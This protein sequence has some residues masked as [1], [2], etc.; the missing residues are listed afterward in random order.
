MARNSKMRPKRVKHFAL[1]V[2]I[3]TLK[4][5]VLFDTRISKQKLRRSVFEMIHLPVEDI[6]VVGIYL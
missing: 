6:R 3:P 4:V 5:D 2:Q 1:H